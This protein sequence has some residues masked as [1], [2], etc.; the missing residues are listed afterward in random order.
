MDWGYVLAA[1]IAGISSFAS[2][3][4]VARSTSDKLLNEMKLQQAVDKERFEAY[5]RQM[6]DTIDSYQ[7]TTNEKIDSM[8]RRLEGQQEWG[9]RIALLEADMNR[10]KEGNI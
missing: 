8:T 6:K 9:T 4:K 3:I 10:M 5:Q 7:R 1:L 2:A